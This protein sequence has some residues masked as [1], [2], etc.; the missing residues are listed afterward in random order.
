MFEDADDILGDR[1]NSS[2]SSNSV[3]SHTFDKLLGFAMDN[4]QTP[5]SSA[6]TI[7]DTLDVKPPILMLN[8][9][10]GTFMNKQ[11]ELEEKEMEI[12]QVN[13]GV[14]YNDFYGYQTNHYDRQSPQAVQ[15]SADSSIQ[16]KSLNDKAANKRKDVVV[17]SNSTNNT[18]KNIEIIQFI[19]NSL[20][21]KDKIAKLLKSILDLIKL[22]LKNS[23]NNI[24]KWDIYIQSYY[25]KFISM[26]TSN[27]YKWKLLIKHP[28]SF[29]KISLLIFME[30]FEKK[31]NFIT[32]QLTLFRYMLRFGN[33]PFRLLEFK[34]KIQNTIK[35]IYIDKTQTFDLEY[36]NKTWF[37]ERTL[38]DFLALYYGICDELLLLHKL[39][40][41]SNK[42]MYKFVDRHSTISSQYDSM[43]AVK[44]V[45][46]KIKKISNEQQELKIQLQV[47]R[48]AMRLTANLRSSTS[49]S[50]KTDASDR[51]LSP[52]KKQ[53]VEEMMR[54]EYGIYN[55][56]EYKINQRLKQLK[57]EKI[58]TILD[59]FRLSTDLAGNSIDYFNVNAPPIASPM[60]SF[61]SALLGCIK[62][63]K[64]AQNELATRKV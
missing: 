23:R 61:I 51:S 60:L 9:D 64:N 62:L 59:F 41:W 7:D 16:N 49:S 28:I 52:V 38:I 11:E 53:L 27:K 33:T 35:E 44:N 4:S 31:S 48:T 21:G 56:S 40:F 54:S 47:R 2:H 57:T 13:N 15:I 20:S 24:L 25:K 43:L 3:A 34:N 29:L 30:N 45:V 26:P 58:N 55:N 22:F 39:K 46:L 37:N 63:W 18:I 10:S 12:N 50:Y 5:Y 17:D 42:S 1:V 8:N 19:I 32:T 6:K 14:K 36:L